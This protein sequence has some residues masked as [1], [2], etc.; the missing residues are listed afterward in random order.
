MVTSASRTAE[1]FPS[2][3][4]EDCNDLSLPCG[5]PSDLR[6]TNAILPIAI[7]V[8]RKAPDTTPPDLSCGPGR[9]PKVSFLWRGEYYVVRP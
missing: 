2:L 1:T 6:A 5:T 3:V 7:S 9:S 4:L 8:E